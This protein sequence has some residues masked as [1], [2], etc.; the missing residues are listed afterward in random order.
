MPMPFSPQGSISEQDLEDRRNKFQATRTTRAEQNTYWV[1]WWPVLDYDAYHHSKYV[2][3]GKILLPFWVH[4][5]CFLKCFILFLFSWKIQCWINRAQKPEYSQILGQDNQCSEYHRKNWNWKSAVFSCAFCDFRC[6]LVSVHNS[7]T[8][9]APHHLAYFMKDAD[10]T[11]KNVT[12]FW[13]QVWDSDNFGPDTLLAVGEI[14]TLAW[15]SVGVWQWRRLH[16][17]GGHLTYALQGALILVCF[18]VQLSWFMENH[19]ISRCGLD[20]L[21]LVTHMC[22]DHITLNFIMVL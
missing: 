7:M 9:L 19:I 12:I 5:C 21:A 4:L 13:A 10:L 8:Q 15:G 16:L 3:I 1:N 2:C 11:S 14:R 6:L 18:V 20:L 17:R 22:S